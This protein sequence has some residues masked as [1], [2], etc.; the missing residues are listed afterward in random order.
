MIG[1]DEYAHQDDIGGV[2]LWWRNDDE[3]L[4]LAI[5]SAT[6]GWVSVGIDPVNRMEGANYIICA[7]VDGEASVW[8]TYGTA[9]TGANHPPDEDLG[10]TSD[11]VA[12]AA[13]EEDGHTRC[14]VQ[15]PLDS[16]DEFDK[17][18]ESGGTYAAITAAASWDSYDGY[19]SSRAEGAIELD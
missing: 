17:R 12:F 19:H 18:L 11:I 9:P 8:D 5:E 7:V 15:I 14:E 6:S 13:V 1:E 10:G 4:F 3:F 16:G 2:R